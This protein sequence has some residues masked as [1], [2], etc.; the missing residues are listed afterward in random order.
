MQRIIDQAVLNYETLVLC[1]LSNKIPLDLPLETAFDELMKKI[2]PNVGSE[3]KTSREIEINNRLILQGYHDQWKQDRHGIH[4]G[5]NL[6]DAKSLGEAKELMDR[7]YRADPEGYSQARFNSI[8][9]FGN[10]IYSHFLTCNKDTLDKM[11]EASRAATIQNLSKL[12]DAGAQRITEFKKNHYLSLWTLNYRI[13]A[14]NAM[15][16][17]E[18]ERIFD[19]HSTLF[20]APSSDDSEMD[21]SN[22]GQRGGQRFTG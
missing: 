3:V 16:P 7:E 2:P 22:N 1:A 10:E 14:L 6:R 15:Y 11:V 17:N 21:C 19:M 12:G 5:M 8:L 20:K 13:T 4:N 9:V 18:N